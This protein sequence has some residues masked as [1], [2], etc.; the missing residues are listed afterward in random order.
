MRLGV[1]IGSTT[2]KAV[3]LN[4]SGVIIFSR[5]I[6]HK[7]RIRSCIHSLMQEVLDAFGDVFIEFSITGS[8]GMGLAE[9]LDLDFVQ[10]VI[11]ASEV[12]QC[13]FPDTHTLIDIGG[14]DAKMIFFERGKVPDIRMNGSCAGGTGA[15]IDQ[16]AGLLNVPVENLNEV[17]QKSTQIYPI[18]SRC[19]VFAKTDVQNLIS[20]KIPISDIAASA[21]H[22]IALQTINSLARGVDLHSKIVCVGGP[23]T[24]ISE[25]RKAFFSVLSLPSSDFVF[26]QNGELFPAWGAALLA[27]D[28]S[29]VLLSDLILLLNRVPEKVTSTRLEPLFYDESEFEYWKQ[30]RAII[31]VPHE[32]NSF[33]LPEVF[34]GIDSGSTTTKIVCITKE[35]SISASYYGT[36]NGKP[37]DAV[38][39]GIKSCSKQMGGQII[40]VLRSGVTGYGEDLIRAAFSID[41][42]I[43][44]TIAHVTASQKILPDVSFILDIGG[45]DMKAIYLKDGFIQ[46]IEINEACSS[47]CGSFVQNFAENLSYTPADFG[48]LACS[49]KHPCDLGSRCTVFMNSQVKQ[50]LREGAE[51]SDI[52]AG[53]A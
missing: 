51:V 34:L 18:A 10:E 40:K 9:Q 38:I 26:P 7:A 39:A 11:A 5:Y 50:S 27:R 52:A 12:I 36:N 20:R 45:Q 24:F 43:V 35:G 44:E 37:V 21:F 49:A 53:L 23:L 15:F 22:A 32:Q 8:A 17:A 47:G 19:G 42:G 28:S 41:E 16:I 46:N 4:D 13:V 1:D 25:L 14:E 33:D 29:S 30:Q 2:A 48:N 3:L 6:R 31:E